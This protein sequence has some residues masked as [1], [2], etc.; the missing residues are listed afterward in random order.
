MALKC[1]KRHANWFRQFEDVN[2]Y[3]SWPHLVA[4][5]FWPTLFVY[6]LSF[7]TRLRKV[8]TNLALLTWQYEQGR[9]NDT[10][11]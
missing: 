6:Y 1:A 9:N 4:S 3:T 8:I 2:S 11:V 7:S 5:L 10:G